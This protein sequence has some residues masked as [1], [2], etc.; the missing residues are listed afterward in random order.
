[1]R[2]LY[3]VNVSAH[4]LAAV[5]WLGGLFFLAVIGAPV[6]RRLESPQLRARLFRDIG[7]RFRTVGWT[8]IVILVATGVLN[9][10]FVGLLDTAVLGSQ[11]FWSSP[12]GRALLWK[13]AAV[14]AMLALSASHDFMLGPAASRLEAGSAEAGRARRWASLLARMTALAGLAVV[15]AAVRLARGG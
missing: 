5:F 14:A 13:L 3:F 2:T 1:V 9:L 10:F 11:A 6:L 15:L 12:Y 4:V 7:Q 8:L